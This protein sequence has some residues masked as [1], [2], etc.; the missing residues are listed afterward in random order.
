MDADSADVE[1]IR[2]LLKAQDLVSEFES[3]V[4]YDRVIAG[5]I[6]DAAMAVLAIKAEL[7]RR[8]GPSN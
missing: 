4:Q 2:Y 7:E 5:R 6:L 3:L 1:A 8:T